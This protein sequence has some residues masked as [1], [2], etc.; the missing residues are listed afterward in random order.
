MLQHL[1]TASST[2]FAGYA[3]ADWQVSI[4]SDLVMI[5][6]VPSNQLAK[7]FIKQGGRSRLCY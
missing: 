6:P 4:N 1:F 2:A 5:P 3:V 7:Q